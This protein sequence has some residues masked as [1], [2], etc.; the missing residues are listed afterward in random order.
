ML[1][2][3]DTLNPVPQFIVTYELTTNEGP[4]AHNQRFKEERTAAH[5]ADVLRQ[6]AET[7]ENSQGFEVFDVRWGTE[8]MFAQDVRQ[9]SVVLRVP[10]PPPAGEE[11]A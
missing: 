2:T 3:K 6:I 5:V 8:R 4:S 7:L 10:D 9:M 11:H 1:I